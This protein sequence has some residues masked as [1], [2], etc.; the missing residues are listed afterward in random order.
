MLTQVRPGRKRRRRLPADHHARSQYDGVD[1]PCTDRF[2]GFNRLSAGRAKSGLRQRIAHDAARNLPAQPS[3]RQKTGPKMLSDK[4]PPNRVSGVIMPSC[5]KQRTLQ[6]NA[7]QGFALVFSVYQRR[8]R[9]SNPRYALT[10]TI[11]FESTAFD[12]S[13]ISPYFYTT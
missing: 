9:D 5:Q 2:R 10:R 4:S 1:R 6:T 12:H 11:D 7:L 3:R 13:A 8:D